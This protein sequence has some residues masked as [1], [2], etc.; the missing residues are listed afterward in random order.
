MTRPPK[1]WSATGPPSPTVPIG[2]LTQQFLQDKTTC[3]HLRNNRYYELDTAKNT[4]LHKH[5]LCDGTVVFTVRPTMYELHRVLKTTRKTH[6]EKQIPTTTKSPRST[7]PLSPPHIKK[8]N[9]SFPQPQLESDEFQI[10]TN[11]KSNRKPLQN[12][13]PKHN[14]PSPEHSFVKLTKLQSSQFTLSRKNKTTSS[15][16]TINAYLHHPKLVPRTPSTLP[17]YRDFFPATKALKEYLDANPI[18]KMDLDTA[19]KAYDRC[20]KHSLGSFVPGHHPGEMSL[21]LLVPLLRQEHQRIIEEYPKDEKQSKRIQV[22]LKKIANA[23]KLLP[24]RLFISKDFPIEY[25]IGLTKEQLQAMIHNHYVKDR[26]T[27]PDFRFSTQESLM[28]DFRYE[29]FLLKQAANELN[30]PTSANVSD[31]DFKYKYTDEEKED[32]K[33]YLPQRLVI[34]P[35]FPLKALPALRGNQMEIMLQNHYNQNNVNVP[36]FTPMSDTILLSRIHLAVMGHL[37][38]D[39]ISDKPEENTSNT[40]TPTVNNN[41]STKTKQ[42]R[43]P[44]A[45]DTTQ[46][47]PSQTCKS[48]SKKQRSNPENVDVEMEINDNHDT[49]VIDNDSSSPVALEQTS[50][51][52]TIVPT[53]AG[54]AAVVVTQ[55]DDTITQTQ[56]SPTQPTSQEFASSDAFFNT[57]FETITNLRTMANT[58]INSL[59]KNQAIELLFAYSLEKCVSFIGAH[60]SNT[61]MYL[62]RRLV[63]KAREV[64]NGHSN[65]DI[66]NDEATLNNMALL[67][68]DTILGLE[69]VKVDEYLSTYARQYGIQ[70]DESYYTKTPIEQKRIQ[71]GKSTKEYKS[72]YLTKEPTVVLTE[73]TTDQMIAYASL[74]MV[75]TMF[76]TYVKT[77]N[78]DLSSLPIDKMSHKEL[79]DECFKVRNTLRI[80]KNLP[81]L[82][83]QQ[84][85]KG[86][87]PFQ[88]NVGNRNGNLF[89]K[90]LPKTPNSAIRKKLA[91]NESGQQAHKFEQNDFYVRVSAPVKGKDVHIPTVIKL[92][93]GKLRQ[94]DP[95]FTLMTFDRKDTSKNNTIAKEDAIPN[96]KKDLHTWIQGDYITKN[97]KLLFSMRCTNNIPFKDVR[98]LL[99]IWQNDTGIK[100][101]FDCVVSQSLFPAGWLKCAHPRL[102]NRDSLFEWIVDQSNTTM[103][104]KIHLYPRIMFEYRE[105]GS[106]A[107]TEVLVIDGAYNQKKTIKTFLSSIKW[108]GFYSDIEFIPFQSN[109]DDDTTKQIQAIDSHNEFCSK[110]TSMVITIK[111]PSYVLSDMNGQRHTFIDWLAAKTHKDVPIFYEV[112]QIGVT[113]VLV[114]YYDHHVE[115]VDQFLNTAH[116][117]FLSEYQCEIAEQIF[118]TIHPS[119]ILCSA[120]RQSNDFFKRL[121]KVTSQSPT[122][123]N[124]PQRRVNAFYGQEPLLTTSNEAEIF[125]SKSYSDAAQN[126]TN[127]NNDVVRL[128]QIVNDLQSQVESLSQTLATNVSA[129][130][131]KEVDTKLEAVEERLNA[132]IST[133]KEECEARIANVENKFNEIMTKLDT[134]NST[135]LAAIRGESKPPSGD[136]HSARGAGK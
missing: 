111:R 29:V 6:R 30:V 73:N 70:V 90:F 129:T 133:V 130:V 103:K 116:S 39:P 97:N 68:D 57:H 110:I 115:A 19:R 44:P 69:K 85:H 25:L 114:A 32:C 134:N 62:L 77:F 26:R 86:P 127:S 18:E 118:G 87:N 95:S 74:N 52:T 135:L 9:T 109:D 5:E 11:K 15:T 112:E 101:N 79:L 67:D 84:P 17:T 51:S 38:A 63:Y 102:L 82:P 104:S 54:M 61:P 106:K 55:P 113:K 64:L 65:E 71:L 12:I 99:N 132:N 108:S 94:A 16:M 72:L 13:A 28:L 27:P 46:T 119:K 96:D 58:A 125:G 56:T 22:S 53:E 98:A 78:V 4:F 21:A 14:I 75:K 40:A 7:L 76:E 128:S 33:M 126:N 47:S 81:P 92:V 124:L 89:S 50:T 1:W 48:P 66:L 43:S 122:D 80:E 107:L 121:K 123:N 59:S 91:N 34:T 36:D 60:Y 2:D 37:P 41:E 31:I 45:I 88:L 136:D 100:V 83:S 105:D 35:R 10:V 20:V 49:V 131:L 3:D 24:K 23:R 8:F 117:I 42:P 93:F 120:P